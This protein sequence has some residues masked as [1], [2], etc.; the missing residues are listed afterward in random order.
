MLDFDITRSWSG[1]EATRAR[2]RSDRQRALLQVVIDH[3]RAELVQDLDA[4]MATLVAEPSFH[5]WVQGRDIGPK[6]AEAVSAYYDAFFRNGGAIF[7]SV[8]ERVLVDD[9][10][11]AHEG[12]TRNLL[13][14][15]VAK[16]RGY[17]VPDE[18]AHYL[19]EF[20]N[21]VWWSFDDDGLALGEDSC[22]TISLDAW[23]LVPHA[24]LPAVYLDYVERIHW[25]DR[26]TA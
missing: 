14:G 15:R 4:V 26:P 23:Q 6:G 21:F 11:V 12:P 3:I 16:A 2:L 17:A 18:S 5:V 8:K 9:R 22:T 10:T 19:V 7:E 25:E 20:R 13:P 1:I 24:E